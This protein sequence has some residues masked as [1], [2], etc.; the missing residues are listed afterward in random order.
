LTILF[1]I[2][3][4]LVIDRTGYWTLNLLNFVMEQ[5]RRRLAARREER[6]ARQIVET[7]KRA[8]D[9][10]IQKEKKRTP[11]RIEP[12]IK[13]PPVRSERVEKERQGKLFTSRAP[14]DLPAISLLDERKNSGN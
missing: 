8:L 3:W 6:N 4:L 10:H 2:S 13:A 11:P 14:G 12:V 7:R 9:V 5:L 1:H